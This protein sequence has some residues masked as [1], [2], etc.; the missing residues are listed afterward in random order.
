MKLTDLIV[1]IRGHEINTIYPDGFRKAR[2]W[3]LLV[4]FWQRL[5][6]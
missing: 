3:R 4:R 2:A 1:E 5:G 6:H